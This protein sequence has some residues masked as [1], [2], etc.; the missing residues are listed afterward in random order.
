MTKPIYYNKF[1]VEKNGKSVLTKEQWQKVHKAIVEA[2]GETFEVVSGVSEVEIDHENKIIY[3]KIP[4][5]DDTMSLLTQEQQKQSHDALKDVAGEYK[6]ITDK[7][8]IYSN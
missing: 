7:G 4:R 6:V 5:W 2:I 3:N 1:F 8:R